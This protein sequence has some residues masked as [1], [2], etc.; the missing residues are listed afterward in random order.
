[1]TAERLF[2]ICEASTVDEA[3]AKGEKLGWQR[4]SDA[5]LEEWRASF[6]GYNGGS[7]EVLGWQ[8]ET[9]G[10]AVSLSFWIATG[11]N[12]HKAC[13]FSTKQPGD[14]LEAISERLG[15]PDSLNKDDALGVVSASWKRDGAE[16]YF[17]Q[18]GSSVAVNVSRPGAT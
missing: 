18:V 8:Q 9:P 17:S 13:S 7:V 5:Q 2:D 15:S 12:A 1:M 6:V 3:A 10:A 16:Y 14:L 11:P 4:M